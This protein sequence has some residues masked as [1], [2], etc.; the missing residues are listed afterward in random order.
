MK[1]FVA[2]RSREDYDRV[3]H[4]GSVFHT[5]YFTFRVLKQ[6]IQQTRVA[7]VVSKKV[8][9]KATARNLMR[10]RIREYI[11]TS[12]STT[13]GRDIIVHVKPEAEKLPRK[14]LREC[15]AEA[16]DSIKRKGAL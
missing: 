15:L 11:R 6:K 13:G 2:L 9:T 10:R 4:Q 5:K 7:I 3:F 12:E 1:T 8:S 16:V 14:E